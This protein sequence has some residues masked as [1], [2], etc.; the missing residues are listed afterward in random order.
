MVS[1]PIDAPVGASFGEA[2]GASIGASIGVAIAVP[3]P[4]ATELRAHRASFGDPQAGSVPT[5]VTLVPPV[6]VTSELAQVETHLAEVASR[7]QPFEMLLRGTGTFRP[8]SPVVF[9]AVAQGIAE[10]E[11]LAGDARAGPLAVEPV[12]PYHPHVTVA[13]HVDDVA[14]DKAFDVLADYRCDF[15]VSAFV[16]YVHDAVD[17]WHQ[18]RVYSL[19]LAE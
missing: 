17:G 7:H 12:F 1:M 8:V 10:C 19:G 13:H 9:V 5:H 6:T 11:L 4:H 3:E 18:H 14:L 15:E 16:L 2:I